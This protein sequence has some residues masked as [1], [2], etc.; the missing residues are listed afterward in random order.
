MDRQQIKKQTFWSRVLLRLA[1]VF[2][3]LAGLDFAN[4]K[5]T[6]GFIELGLSIIAVLMA[7]GLL[8]LLSRLLLRQ[9]AGPEE[10]RV[11]RWKT[12][13]SELWKRT[14]RCQAVLGSHSIWDR[15]RHEEHKIALLN[16][17]ILRAKVEAN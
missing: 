9:V 5:Q 8:R 12:I 6:G 13:A 17:E 4:G 2:T 15:R 3:L 7:L 11:N 1:V 16:N 14:R 10:R